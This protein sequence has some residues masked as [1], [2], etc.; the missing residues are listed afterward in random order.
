MGAYLR[1]PTCGEEDSFEVSVGCDNKECPSNT[2][3]GTNKQL[4]AENEALKQ[5]IKALELDFETVQAPISD[6]E[7][8]FIIEGQRKDNEALQAQVAVLVEALFQAEPFISNELTEHATFIASSH[9]CGPESLCDQHCAD[10]AIVKKVYQMVQSC[11]SD[12]QPTADAYT[13]RVQDE[14]V[15]EYKKW[16]EWCFHRLKD[17]HRGKPEVWNL[18]NG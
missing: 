12:L 7:I 14:A 8:A 6:P 16:L 11:L 18:I 5:Q 9:I 1:C 4:Q 13:K 15:A 10:Y 2:V 3:W 17:E